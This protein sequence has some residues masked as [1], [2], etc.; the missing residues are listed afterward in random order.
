MNELIT[1]LLIY[2]S[3]IDNAPF[4][5]L[6]IIPYSVFIYYLYKIKVINR[7]IKFGFSLTIF[8][9]GVTIVFSILSETIYQ[10]SLVEIDSFHGIAESFLTLADLVILYGFATLLKE[11]EVKNS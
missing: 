11:I 8:F 9:V 4:F 7:I 5:A 3:S 2:L 6:S 10:K 1:K